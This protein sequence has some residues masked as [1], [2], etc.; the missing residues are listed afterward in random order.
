MKNLF[1]KAHK[2]TKEIK[3]E[4]PN[5]NY[6][7]QF[8]LCLSYLQ[9]KEENK[10]VELKGSEKQIK[11]ADEIRKIVLEASKRNIELKQFFYDEYPGKKRTARRLD[12]AKKL[13]EKMKNEES[14]KFF[15]EN[16]AFLQ[17]EKRTLEK[18]AK[19]I[20]ISAINELTTAFIDRVNML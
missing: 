1:K 18:I 6:K 5:V 19:E 20:D 11:W 16:F 13:N 14:A 2:L 4:Y 12:E 7:A 3:A 15:I 9:E 10:L 17:K 8:G